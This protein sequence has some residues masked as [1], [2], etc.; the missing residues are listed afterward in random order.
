MLMPVF[1]PKVFIS[2]REW[3]EEVQELERKQTYT[4]HSGFE[5][6][7]FLGSRWCLIDR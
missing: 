1:R 3:E 4:Q 5:L 6:Q 7:L 2:K